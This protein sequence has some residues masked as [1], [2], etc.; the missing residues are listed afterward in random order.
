MSSFMGFGTQLYGKRD[1]NKLD[2]SY[3]ATNWA[4]FIFLPLWPL[5]SYRVWRGKTTLRASLV[6]FST[7]TSIRTVGVPLNKK[8][9]LW[10]YIVGLGAP[11]SV[12]YLLVLYPIL[13]L[14]LI[15]LVMALV[16]VI[17]M[18]TLLGKT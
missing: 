10:T 6:N 16:F 15:F 3:I 17:L 14:L 4:I 7:Q 2:G 13:W 1:V 5:A 12:I 8:Q 11:L 18:L 9:I